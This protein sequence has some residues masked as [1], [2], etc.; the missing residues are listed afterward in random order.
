MATEDGGHL[1]VRQLSH[2][3]VDVHVIAPDG[4]TVATVVKPR[5]DVVQQL[6]AAGAVLSGR[7][8]V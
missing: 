3:L 5:A 8:A 6:G 7:F 4:R 1:E 2:G